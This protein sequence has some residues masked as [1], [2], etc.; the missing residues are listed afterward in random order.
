MPAVDGQAILRLDGTDFELALT[1]QNNSDVT[2]EDATL[3]LGFTAVSLGD[4]EPG[5]IASQNQTVSSSQAAIASGSGTGLGFSS[6]SSAPSASPLAA[7]YDILLGTTNYYNDSEVYPRWQL[8]ESISPEFG[9]APGW[10]PRD[11]VTLIAWSEESQLDIDLN[12][13]VFEASGT[14][15]YFLE[16]PLDQQAINGQNM[17]V[18]RLFLDWQ[19]LGESGIYDPTINN[20]YLPQ[21]WI[22]FEY[23]PWEEFRTMSVSELA[24]L[25]QPPPSNTSQPFPKLQL[26]DW[27]EGVWITI[28]DANWGKTVVSSAETFLGPGNVVRVRVQND[29]SVGIDVSE[30]YPLI[31]GDMS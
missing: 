23:Q 26:W 15:L 2:L 28:E 27:A 17:T 31:T 6:L 16:L 3:L 14:T 9:S 7:N 19:V 13:N 21:G 30:V 4:L 29:F 8:L 22:E 24:I 25:V 12:G 18:P 11:T 20:L 5:E 1:V 10:F